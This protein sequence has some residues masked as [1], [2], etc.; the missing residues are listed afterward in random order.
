[1]VGLMFPTNAHAHAHT[2]GRNRDEYSLH[3]V[4]QK[5][6]M[7]S[8]LE[9][10]WVV[11]TRHVEQ[12][13]VLRWESSSDMSQSHQHR[14]ANTARG[15]GQVTHEISARGDEMRMI[16]PKVPSKIAQRPSI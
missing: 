11:T 2:H 3:A 4:K 5:M 7:R 12:M 9:Y 6:Q 1:M 15:G 16:F 8:W 13:L 14:K 10:L